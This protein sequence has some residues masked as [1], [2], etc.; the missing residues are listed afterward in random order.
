[1]RKQL[2]ICNSSAIKDQVID[3][4]VDRSFVY[5]VYGCFDVLISNV[6]SMF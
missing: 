1:M 4:K 6:H 2:F 5:M 3:K